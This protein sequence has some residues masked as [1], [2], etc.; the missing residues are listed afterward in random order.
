MLKL[1]LKKWWV[2]LLQGILLIILSIYIFNNPETVLTGLSLWIGILVLS[3]GLLGIIAWVAADTEAREN[4]SLLWSA[5]TA[6]LGVVML[7]HLTSTMKTLTVLFG[8]WML[9][10]GLFFLNRGWAV[11]DR[12]SLGWIMVVAGVLSAIAAV[13]MIFDMG[14]GAVGISTLLGISV[15]LTGIA[16]IVLSIVKKVVVGHVKDKVTALKQNLSN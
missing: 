1:L 16:L 11:K 8:I 13:M 4:M 12:S 7:L 2:I 14:T 6:V 3:A 10:T 15:L 9:V 5:L